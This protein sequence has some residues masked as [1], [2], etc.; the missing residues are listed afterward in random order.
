MLCSVFRAPREYEGGEYSEYG[1]Q[2][3]TVESVSSRGSWE[4]RRRVLHLGRQARVVLPRAEADPAKLKLARGVLARHVVA[5]AILLDRGLALRARLRVGHQP[6][7]RL[8][9]VLA[10]D[11]PLLQILDAVKPSRS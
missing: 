11:D 5:A 3:F 10:L 8:R 7:E 1:R 2:R 4:T 6:V 9:I